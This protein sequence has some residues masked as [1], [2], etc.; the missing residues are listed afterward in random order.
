MSTCLF[1]SANVP[2]P[3]VSNPHEHICIEINPITHTVFDG[4]APDNFSIEPL[5]FDPPLGALHFGRELCWNYP[6][7]ERVEK[8]KSYIRTVLEKTDR[9]Q[10]W[11]IWLSEY[12]PPKVKVTS[13]HIDELSIAVMQVLEKSDIWN[14]PDP[15][16]PTYYCV[17]ITK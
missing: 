11:N 15:D 3:V 10:I 13:I 14:N 4:D 8:L 17:N 2:L 9:V 5:H 1:L 16:T 12:N 7:A 6:T